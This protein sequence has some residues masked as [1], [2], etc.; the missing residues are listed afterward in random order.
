MKRHRPASVTSTEDKNIPKKGVGE[1]KVAQVTKQKANEGSNRERV[2]AAL[3]AR[4]VPG[5]Q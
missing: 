3:S 2:T 4:K 1:S 5:M